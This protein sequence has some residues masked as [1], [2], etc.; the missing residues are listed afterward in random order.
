MIGK[1]GGT[2][3]RTQEYDN[4]K[5]LLVNG[6]QSLFDPLQKKVLNISIDQKIVSVYD[7]IARTWTKQ[8]DFPAVGTHYWLFNKYFSRSDTSI[9]MIGGYG[10]FTY[11]SSVLRYHIPS[12]SWDSIPLLVMRSFLITWL[13]WDRAKTGCI[14]PEVMAVLRVTRC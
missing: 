5:L 3:L 8:F 9:Y 14:S 1:I 2:D 11:K 6:S 7:S 4:G 12:Q 13:E 10:H